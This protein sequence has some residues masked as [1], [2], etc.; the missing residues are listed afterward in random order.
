MTCAGK[1]NLLLHETDEILGAGTNVGLQLSIMKLWVVWGILLDN[2]GS[3]SC[4]QASMCRTFLLEAWV[5]AIV[6]ST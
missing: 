4:R 5:R 6:P 1:V 3:L 2:K